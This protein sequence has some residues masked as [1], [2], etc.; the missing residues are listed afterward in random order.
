MARFKV[1]IEY[2]G[3][4]YSGWQAQK[5]A[6]TVEG[7]LLAALRKVFGTTEFEFYG[8]GRTD[9]GV[10]ALRQVAHLDAPTV[11]APEIITRKLNDVL[12]VDINVLEVEKARKDFHA[13][14]DAVER[15]YLYQIS[16]RRTALAKRY[17][18][19]VKEPLD[20]GKM[21]KAAELFA[22]M[23]D[24]RSFTS[25]DPGERSTKVLIEGIEIREAGELVLIRIRGSHFLWGLVRQIVGALVE[26]GC[27]RLTS[28][29]IGLYLATSSDE[30]SRHTAPASGLFLERVYYAGD[31]RLTRLE[32][33]V[34]VAER[35]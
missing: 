34:A 23:K 21:Q 3:T 27:R 2:E 10:H 18:W 9:A 19:W 17:V 4:R 6:R 7:E 1:S 22:G 29:E 24:L 32:P 30:P 31:H 35:L 11:L 20:I 12:P 26:A 8:A 28:E 33:V 16:R 14:H 13:R 15:S 5:N 25:D